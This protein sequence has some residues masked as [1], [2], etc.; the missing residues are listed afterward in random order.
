MLNRARADM[1]RAPHVAV[2]PSLAIF[3]TVPAFNLLGDGLR[4]ALDP[5]VERPQAAPGAGE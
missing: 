3:L 1:V 2:F 5:T 4:E